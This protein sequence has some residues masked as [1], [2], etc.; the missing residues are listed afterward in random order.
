MIVGFAG[1]GIVGNFGCIYGYPHA[2]IVAEHRSIAVAGAFGVAQVG[3]CSVAAARHSGCLIFVEGSGIDSMSR[4]ITATAGEGIEPDV[5]YR[6]ES[7]RQ[8][9]T[10]HL[11]L[12]P[13]TRADLLA[14]HH[15][16]LD[17]E[18]KRDDKR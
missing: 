4:A 11:R 9:L 14:T 6:V 8:K 18:R 17:E 15:I 16:M 1:T 2:R 5:L 3:N 10:E 7:R 12:V 13:A